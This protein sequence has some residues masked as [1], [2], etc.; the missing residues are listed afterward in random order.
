M[1]KKAAY[2]VCPSQ[3]LERP[4]ASAA[5]LSA[6]LTDNNVEYKIYDLNL[7]IYNSLPNNDWLICDKHWRI[8]ETLELPVSFNSWFNGVV[9]NIIT[10]GYDLIAVSVFSKFSTRFANLLIKTLRIKTSA[11]IITGGQGLTTPWGTETFGHIL[12]KEKLVDYVFTGDG[13]ESLNQFLKGNTKFPGIN[14]IPP[15]QIEDLSSLPFPIYDQINPHD[16]HFHQDAGIYVTASRGCVRKCKFCDVPSRWPKY[17]Y[18]PGKD[19]AQ[20]IYNSYKRTNVNVI[21]FTDSVINGN[22]REFENLQDALIEFKQLD[23]NFKPKWLSQFNIRK[24][25]DM[26]EELYSKMAQAGASVLVCGV[27]HASWSIREAMGKEFDN[28]DLDYH[29]KMCAKYGIRNVFLMFIGYPT[30]TAEDHREMLD[31]LETY[32]TYMLAGTIMVIRWGYTGSL[33]HGSRLEL[34]QESMDIVPEWP[35]LKVMAIDDQNQDWI[36]GRNWINLKNPTL[37]FK[38]RIRRRLEIH[39]RSVELGWPITRA[40]EELEILK[41]MC[42]SF[43]SKDQKKVFVIEDIGDH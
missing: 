18:R 5:A 21:Q 36:Y 11:T 30:E 14:F 39:E 23:K 16:Y 40:R 17:K 13:E 1:Y 34:L 2:I 27:E 25:R 32:Q 20:E 38:E 29:I 12:Y 24:K 42:E 3:E 8:D 7:D 9:H 26:P 43:Y 33:D 35:D 19:V 10:G 22:L 28:E 37:T 6:V 4:P 41:I 31:F 15:I